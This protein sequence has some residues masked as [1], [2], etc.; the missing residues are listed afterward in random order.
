MRVHVEKNSDSGDSSLYPQ[1]KNNPRTKNE[2]NIDKETR[3]ALMASF[4]SFLSGDERM[5]YSYS[6]VFVAKKAYIKKA[7]IRGF[8]K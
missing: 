3:H 1:R 7:T 6:K 5:N 4:D 8:S 2:M